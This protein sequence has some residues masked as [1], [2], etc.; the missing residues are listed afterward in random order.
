[1]ARRA[2]CDS[3]RCSI[4]RPRVFAILA[5][6][7]AARTIAEASAERTHVSEGRQPQSAA[8]AYA[9]ERIV[10]TPVEFTAAGL[11]SKATDLLEEEGDTSARAF[12]A[13][14][15]HPGHVHATSPWPALA[16]GDHPVNALEREALEG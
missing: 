1:M 5:L 14:L 10:S 9:G 16:A 15:P 11:R 2:E 3:R 6:G 4:A 13:Q 8:P 12:V 7:T